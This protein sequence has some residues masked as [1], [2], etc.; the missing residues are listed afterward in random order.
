MRYFSFGRLNVVYTE[1]VDGTMQK[2]EAKERVRKML[3]LKALF[4]PTLQRHTTKVM[5]GGYKGVG[6]GVYV[7]ERGVGVGIVTADC[8]GIIMSDGKRVMALHAGWKGLFGGIIK[9]GLKQFEKV[10][11]V[12]VFIG[13]RIDKCCYEVKEDFVVEAKKVG[14]EKFIEERG[15]IKYFSLLEMAIA[16]LIKEGIRKNKIYFE[17]RCTKCDKSLF[18]YRNEERGKV[19]LTVGWLD[20]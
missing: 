17:K 1:R 19:F 16:I 14:G 15:K 5:K 6:D 9:A 2:E 20:W 7:D 3:G 12:L 11:E 4:T 8:M 18:S 13:P 10:D